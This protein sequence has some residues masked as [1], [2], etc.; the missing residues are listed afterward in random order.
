MIRFAL[1]SVKRIHVLCIKDTEN[2]NKNLEVRQTV[3]DTETRITQ[4]GNFKEGL[5]IVIYH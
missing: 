3:V 1:E 2:W 5:V 4:M